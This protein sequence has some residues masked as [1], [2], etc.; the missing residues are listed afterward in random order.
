M[1]KEYQHKTVAGFFTAHRDRWIKG[2]YH[3]PKVIEGESV[4]CFCLVGRVQEVEELETERQ[5]IY[6][7]LV[8]AIEKLHPTIFKR[9][10]QDNTANEDIIIGFNDA[11]HRTINQIINVAREA[12]V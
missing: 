2:S 5:R 7:R 4:S 8:G 1:P 3:T 9:L 12:R 6:K 10:Q 11:P